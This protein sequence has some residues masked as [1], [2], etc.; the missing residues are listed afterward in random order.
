MEVVLRAEYSENKGSGFHV[1]SVQGE[2]R[3]DPPANRIIH[4]IIAGR[5]GGRLASSQPL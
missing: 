5:I 3:S 1:R 2:I 4:F